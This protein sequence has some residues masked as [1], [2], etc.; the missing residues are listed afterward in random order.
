[1]NAKIAALV[2]NNTLTLTLLPSNKKV[3]ACKWVYRVKYKADGSMERYKA[4]LIAKGFTQQEGL[5]FID[6]F[7]PVAQLTTI[8]TFLAISAVKG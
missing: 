5:D 1:M 8:K 3:I 4:M 2:S 7:S 6:N